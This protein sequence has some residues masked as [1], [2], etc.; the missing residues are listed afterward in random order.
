MKLRCTDYKG[1]VLLRNRQYCSPLTV[2]DGRNRNSNSIVNRG[3]WL[4]WETS[5]T[6]PVEQWVCNLT[7]ATT[8]Y[9]C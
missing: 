7:Q 4:Q 9:C 8:H 1:E 2:T 6:G 5:T 3:A